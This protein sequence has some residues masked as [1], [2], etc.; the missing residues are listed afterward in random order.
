M[1]NAA[2][3]GNDI[4]V[5]CS[6]WSYDDWVGRFYPTDLAKKNGE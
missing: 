5:G 1:V 6:D 3:F 4:L 2:D